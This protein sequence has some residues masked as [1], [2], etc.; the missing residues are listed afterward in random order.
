MS[1]QIVRTFEPRTISQKTSSRVSSV[2]KKM[3]DKC[4]YKISPSGR[5]F[6]KTYL[7]RLDTWDVNY[8]PISL[9]VNYLDDIAQNPT[10]NYRGFDFKL[11]CSKNTITP[12]KTYK[13]ANRFA[14]FLRTIFP[15][16][17]NL[18]MDSTLNNLTRALKDFDKYLSKPD[19]KVENHPKMSKVTTINSKKHGW[20]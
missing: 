3:Q 18:N 9:K 1:I 11:D 7:T 17:E 14:K 6:E 20:L 5:A 10:M 13:F 2:L 19:F 12:T 8:R 4:Q 15:K 16:K